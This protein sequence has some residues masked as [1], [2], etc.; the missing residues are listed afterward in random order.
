MQLPWRVQCCETSKTQL[1][2]DECDCTGAGLCL[3]KTEDLLGSRL[4][5]VVTQEAF[6]ARQLW[7][8]LSILAY[9]RLRSR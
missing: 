8:A 3:D 2:L 9:D 1:F 5:L 4:R 7:L 6:A